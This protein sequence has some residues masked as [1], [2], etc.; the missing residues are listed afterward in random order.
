MIINKS[1]KSRNN[2]ERNGVIINK[3]YESKRNNE[4]LE[5]LC[6]EV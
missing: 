5:S 6:L 2:K 1:Y 3:S 4:S